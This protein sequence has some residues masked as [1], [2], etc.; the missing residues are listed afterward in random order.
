MNL[1]WILSFSIIILIF[2]LVLLFFNRNK[3]IFSTI[4]FAILFYFSLVPL[5][6]ICTN[7][8]NNSYGKYYIQADF[9]QIFMG[10]FSI[11]LFLIVFLITYKL[12]E[13][14]I[15]S[16]GP[17]MTIE[18]RL[19]KICKI[20]SYLTFWIGGISFGIYIVS[21]GGISSLLSYGEFLRSNATSGSEIVSSRVSILFVPARLITITPITIIPVL[22]VK[23]NKKRILMFIISFMLS[24]IFLLFNSG[25]APIAMFAI[26]FLYPILCKKIKHPWIA[27]ISMALIAIPLLGVMDSLFEYFSTGHFPKVDFNYSDYF[28]GFSYPYSN[29]LNLDGIVNVEGKR[30]F[31]D[32]LTGILNVIP[33]V[34]FS[35]SYEP[36][37]FFYNGADWRIIG[38][39]PNDILTFSYLQGGFVGIIIVAIIL[40]K[41]CERLDV[42]FNNSANGFSYN[43][44]KGA[45]SI[46]LFTMIS[47]ADIHSIVQNQFLLTLSIFCVLYSGRYKKVFNGNVSAQF[48]LINN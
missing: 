43:I 47:S 8:T 36:T 20:V 30:Y 48:V 12:S 44:L 5:F 7:Q 34:S 19:Y 17:V 26:S 16:I 22:K 15:I 45:I 40:A 39:T 14:R 42:I 23:K 3:P 21:F 1:T 13:R 9:F 25:K 4:V 37:S 46:S 10:T 29:V 6:E 38:G 27:I 35:A 32:F 2:A 33:G 28:I 24:V 11:L 41:I 18:Y 31:K